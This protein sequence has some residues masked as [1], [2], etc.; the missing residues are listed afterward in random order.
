[1][2]YRACGSPLPPSVLNAKFGLTLHIEQAKHQRNDVVQSATDWRRRYVVRKL[3]CKL[4]RSST[5]FIY[6]W[7]CFRVIPATMRRS[8]A[9][10]CAPQRKHA[11]R[12]RNRLGILLRST[13][14]VLGCIAMVATSRTTR[15]LARWYGILDGGYSSIGCKLV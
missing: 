15:V 7:S 3:F 5:N 4:A 9:S 2:I 8:H 1:M 13:G 12:G 6:S 14:R 11:N 10:P